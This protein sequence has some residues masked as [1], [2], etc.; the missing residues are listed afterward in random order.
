MKSDELC[1]EKILAVGN[2]FWDLDFL[3]TVCSDLTT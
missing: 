2:A 3:V 1:T